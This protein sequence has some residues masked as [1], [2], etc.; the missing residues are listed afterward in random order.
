M[1]SVAISFTN[2]SESALFIQVDPWAGVYRLMQGGSIEFVAESET[3]T[4]RLTVHDS[5]ETRYLTILDSDEYFVVINGE[6]LHWTE[7]PANFDLPD[8]PSPA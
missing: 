8:P 5:G 1:T 4:P 7:F 6:R 2:E 3:S